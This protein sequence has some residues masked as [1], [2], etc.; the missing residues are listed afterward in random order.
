MATISVI[1]LIAIVISIIMTM[2]VYT[3]T[4]K[5]EL[6]IDQMIKKNRDMADA[7]RGIP[8]NCAENTTGSGNSPSSSMS[9][10]CKQIRKSK[11]SGRLMELG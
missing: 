8:E 1:V 4:A 10:Q 5:A 2:T 3:H 9:V 6:N 7:I 11:E